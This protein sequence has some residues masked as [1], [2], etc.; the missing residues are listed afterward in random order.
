VVDLQACTTSESGLNTN[1]VYPNGLST[2]FPPE[3]VSQLIY[4]RYFQSE[5]SSPALVLN[6]RVHM[7]LPRVSA[8]CLY[9]G[10]AGATAHHPRAG[11]GKF[12]VA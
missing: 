10:A 1:I 11:K 12:E 2:G 5:D 7:N 3:V 6:I 9:A 4:F 8:V